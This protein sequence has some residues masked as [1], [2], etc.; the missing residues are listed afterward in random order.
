MKRFLRETWELWY[1]AMFCPSRLQQRMN[2]WAPAEEKYGLRED[3]HFRDILLLQRNHRFIDQFL[4]LIFL[5]SLPLMRGIVLHGQSLDLILLY[6]TIVTAYNIGIF[7]L[8]IGFHIPLVVYLVYSVNPQVYLIVQDRVQGILSPDSYFA[9]VLTGLIGLLMFYIYELEKT[10]LLLSIVVG[11]LVIIMVVVTTGGNIVAYLVAKVMTFVVPN[12]VGYLVGFLMLYVV[13]FVVGNIVGRIV[14]GIVGR[15]LGLIVGLIVGSIMGSIIGSIMGSIVAKIASL[16]LPLFLLTCWLIAVSLSPT[17]QNWLG[18]IT[19]VT[20]TALGL[21]NQGWLSFLALPLTLMSYYRLS[22]HL[23]FTLIEFL[24]EIFLGNSFD[25][26][27][28]RLL[29]LLPPYSIELIWLPLTNHDRILAAAFRTDA[30]AT[31]TT[32]K[33][34]QASPLPGLKVTIKEALPQ[35]ITDQCTAIENISQLVAIATPKHPFL[36]LLAPTLYQIPT[37]KIEKKKSTKTSFKN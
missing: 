9:L 35:I 3:T 7:S 24:R 12:V 6:G 29:H 19:A 4:L 34:M 15:I 23:I 28:L 11:A 5:F 10:K 20:L 31:M 14:G 18:I 16:P 27:P 22:S 13:I 25:R 30:S 17:M 37:I 21:D 36:P 32:F 2:E 33:K 8:S 1:W 26:N